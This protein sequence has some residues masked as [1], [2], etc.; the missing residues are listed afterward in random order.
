LTTAL[1][2]APHTGWTWLVRVRGDV[3]EARTKVV[4]LPVLEAELY[5]LARDHGGDRARF[6]AERHAGARALALAAVRPHAAGA[7]RAIVLGKQPALPAL[8]QIVASHAMIHTAEG[9]L[10]RALFADA[11]ASCGLEVAR[12][13]APAQSDARW[14][15][16]AGKQ[17]GS[18]W[19]AEV[20][21]AAIAARALA[22]R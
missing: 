21:A 10:W 18:P 22:R 13:L 14:L 7:T 19:T 8:D 1:A 11:C 12:G 20:K 9:E 5:H 3:V 2:L 15:A 17:L 16:A 4:A 6:V